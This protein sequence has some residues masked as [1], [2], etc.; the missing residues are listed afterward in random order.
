MKE[1]L[2]SSEPWIVVFQYI[3]PG[4]VKDTTSDTAEDHVKAMEAQLQTFVDSGA[5]K[6]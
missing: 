6:A 3:R 4:G 1:A 5:L 2:A